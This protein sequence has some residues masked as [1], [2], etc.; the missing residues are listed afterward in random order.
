MAVT[1]TPK[2]AA[3]VERGT[4][5]MRVGEFNEAARVLERAL[6]QMPQVAELHGMQAE[7]L[8]RSER[9]EAALA[10][11]QRALRLRPGWGE[12][13]MLRGNIQAR[14]GRSAE[15]ETSF[16]E[17]MRTLGAAPAL[18]ANLANVLLE[19]G[20]FG[21]ALQAYDASLAGGAD[22]LG[23]ERG[24]AR[25]LLGVGRRAD[26]EA[27]W[28]RVLEREPDSVEALEQLMQIYTGE[29]RLDELEA[30]C[31]RGVALAAKP[32][33]FHVFLGFSAWLR[34][35][36]E[37]ALAHYREAAR[38]AEGSD[39]EMFHE[40]NKNE[41]VALFALGRLRE[42]WER[43]RWRLDREA[44]RGRYPLL[45][46]APAAL[47]AAPALRVRIHQEQGIG[48]ELFFLR[49]AA[50]LRAAGHRLS[51]RGERKLVELLAGRTELFESIGLEGEP[52]ASACDVE[53]QSSDLALASGHDFAPPLPLVPQAARS[54]AALAR[55]HAFGPPPYVGVTWSAGAVAEE[56]ANRGDAAVWLK[57]VPIAELAAA[58]RPLRAGI[59]VLQRRPEAAD[60]AAFTAA[61]GRAAL[62]ASD[63]NDD[64]RDAVAMLASLDDY[65]G[66]SNT[67]MHLL[68]G[69]PGPR[70]RV[71][72]QSPAE[73]R[74]G[75]DGRES[76]WFPGFRLYRQTP[77]RSWNE[78][79]R[80]LQD[81]LEKAYASAT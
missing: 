10:A 27:A 33:I 61:L 74:W 42:G 18:Q 23:L 24:R 58:L 65:V 14:L 45:A 55:L 54:Q 48:D 30:V 79:F 32:A 15:A 70:A 9:L 22:P 21:E 62:D 40:A 4:Q 80:Q 71:L 28:K 72:T 66:M 81:D 11:A 29:R 37:D 31:A 53:L 68:A 6:Q 1:L 25:A 44:L 3:L 49:F 26:A 39:A 38:I 35:R 60:M 76:A 73:W 41:A 13:L 64:L 52:E 19:Q 20:R 46:A 51:Y 57:R 5:L 12:A 34:R 69:L 67:N 78:A 43:Y 75:M 56:R 8:L 59:I 63:I 36:S 7:A 47:A 17:A 16:R 2:V 77:D 50:P